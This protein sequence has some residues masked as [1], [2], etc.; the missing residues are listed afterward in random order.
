MSAAPSP[1]TM[2][3]RRCTKCGQY[4]APVSGCKRPGGSRLGDKGFVC[5]VCTGQRKAA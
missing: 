2:P 4:R 1:I 3:R 5:A